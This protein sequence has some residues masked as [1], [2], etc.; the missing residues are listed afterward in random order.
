MSGIP[1]GSIKINNPTAYSRTIIHEMK[2]YLLY[3]VG[4]EPTER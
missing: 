4:V 2:A 1:P 3:C